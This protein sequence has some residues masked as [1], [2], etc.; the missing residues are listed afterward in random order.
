MSCEDILVDKILLY[1]HISYHTSG[2]V[3]R[4]ANSIGYRLKKCNIKSL[5]VVV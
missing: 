1:M 5:V 3:G 4:A 2:G